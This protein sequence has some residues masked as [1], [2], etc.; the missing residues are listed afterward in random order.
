MALALLDMSDQWMNMD[1]HW[2]IQGRNQPTRRSRSIRCRGFGYGTVRCLWHEYHRFR[3]GTVLVNI[4]EHQD[5]GD[6]TLIGGIAVIARC[7][8][9]GHLY[10]HRLYHRGGR[11]LCAVVIALHCCR[12]GRSRDRLWKAA[13]RLIAGVGTASHACCWPLTHAFGRRVS[14]SDGTIARLWKRLDLVSLS[15][16]SLSWPRLPSCRQFTMDIFVY[17]TEHIDM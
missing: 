17:Y 6:G 3:D 13:K 7:I 16:L 10:G 12:K 11:Y 8:E 1:N 4:G 2:T 15:F 5:G 9:T 14:V